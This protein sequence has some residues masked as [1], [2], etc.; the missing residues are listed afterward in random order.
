VGRQPSPP[1]RKYVSIKTAPL[2]NQRIQD[3]GSSKGGLGV[4]KG[5]EGSVQIQVER[6]VKTGGGVGGRIFISV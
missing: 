2:M 6:T 1:Q 5:E 4:G 3:G